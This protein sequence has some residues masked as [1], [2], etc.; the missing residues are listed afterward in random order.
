MIG[1][2]III[3]PIAQLGALSATITVFQDPDIMWGLTDPAGPAYHPLWY[4]ALL[5]EAAYTCIMILAAVALIILFFMRHWLFPALYLAVF[6][7]ALAYVPIE[8]LMMS[9]VTGDPVPY[10][11]GD[12]K[13]IATLV[14]SALIWI[15]YILVSR[16][17]KNTFIEGRRAPIGA[18][19]T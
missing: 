17:V 15:P 5:I 2:Q 10:L 18:T 14:L 9:T 7:L 11:E 6:G 8:Y 1:L 12:I 4:A 19:R 13:G 3:A 16:R